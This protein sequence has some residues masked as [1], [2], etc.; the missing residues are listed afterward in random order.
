MET[1]A[2]PWSPL[3]CGRSETIESLEGL[4][5]GNFE[6]AW[7]E[8]AERRYAEYRKGLI[9]ARDADA[10]G[11]KDLRAIRRRILRRFP[12]GRL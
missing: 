5:G 10:F 7:I 3:V 11:S 6:K 12:F 8:E 1:A 9:T 4:E 2:G